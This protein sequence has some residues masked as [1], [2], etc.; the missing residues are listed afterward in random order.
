MESGLCLSHVWGVCQFAMLGL[1]V[2]MCVLL[3]VPRLLLRL[4]FS[5]V[6][7]F[8]FAGRFFSVSRMLTPK[9]GPVFTHLSGSIKGLSLA[10]P[11]LIRVNPPR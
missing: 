7:I 9:G 3:G 6:A 11:G 10:N 1:W 8:V 2:S 4:V 5:W